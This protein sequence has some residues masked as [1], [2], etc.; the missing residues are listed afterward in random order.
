VY[1]LHDVG[2]DDSVKISFH[3]IE[4]QVDV[5]V[6]LSLENVDQRYDIGMAVKFLQ[7]DD[8]DY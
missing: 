7:K 3:E 8:L 2:S 1:I 6:V 5:F 4:H